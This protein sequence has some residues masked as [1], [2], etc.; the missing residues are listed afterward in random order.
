MEEQLRPRDQIWFFQHIKFVEVKRSKK[1]ESQDIHG[2]AGRL[3]FDKDIISQRWARFH[4]TLLNETA[5][6]LGPDITF[7]H[8]QY[9]NVP[10]LGVELTEEAVAIALR[11]MTNSKAV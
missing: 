6:K 5:E 10:N 4:N 11:A 2:E 3:L 7:K 8:P 9:T 1:V